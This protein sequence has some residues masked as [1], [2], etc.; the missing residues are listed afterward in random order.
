V[1]N[2][3]NPLD[4][5]TMKYW[6][7]F[8]FLLGFLLP[9]TDPFEQLPPIVFVQSKDAHLHNANGTWLYGE[10]PFNGY[11]LEKDHH[12]LINKMPII[13]GKEHGIARGWYPNGQ[14][15]YERRF[16]KGN[17][18]GYHLGWYPN[19]SKAFVHFFKAD[20]FEGEQRTYFEN[21]RPWQNLHYLHGYEEGK[22]QSWNESGRL[23]NNFTV[24]NGKLYGV[25]GRY[26]CMSVYTH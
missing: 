3:K 8:I 14:K 26:D 18:E 10:K 4:H 17:R 24:K 9:S 12:V 6:F 15:K 19:G 22:Q 7:L 21:G 11:I 20:K 16:I 23:I 2:P 5:L 13:A 25:I 1:K